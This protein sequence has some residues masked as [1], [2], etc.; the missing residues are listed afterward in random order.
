MSALLRIALLALTCSSLTAQEKP[1]VVA[2]AS[3][4]AD[5]VKHIGGDKIKLN[6][7]V[8]I[9]GDPHIYEP[10]P[11][12]A[13]MIAK[14][15]II[16]RNGLTFEG[17]LDELIGNSGTK[18]AVTTVTE[19]IVPI[20]SDQ[21]A[22]AYDPHAWMDLTHGATYID[23]ILAAL[24]QLDPAQEDF[25]RQNHQR[26]RQ[27]FEELD[28]YILSAIKT[29]P[30][31]RRILI[32]SHDAFQYYGRRYGLA[33]ESVMGTSTDADV[34]TSD[35]TRLT[36]IIR[37]SKVPAVFIESTINPK[38]LEQLAKDNDIEIGGSLFAD[39]L[40]D[41]ESSAPTYLAMLRYNTDVIVKA[42]SRE[43]STNHTSELSS[44]IQGKAWY[45]L[46]GIC[47]LLIAVIGYLKF[48]R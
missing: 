22:N 12:D 16:F 44:G 31:E 21:Y 38:L 45:L 17:W 42:L 5:M 13:A 4:I 3:M 40:G 28:Q 34:Q 35:I 11:G 33:L 20:G 9:G 27:E 46:I 48:A 10:T 6:C 29:I 43:M 19:G 25:Y 26:Y 41:E 15:D 39:S 37:K 24:I 8:P 32:T 1:K 30:A 14:S 47:L 18:A 36:G 7:I 2:T 23:N